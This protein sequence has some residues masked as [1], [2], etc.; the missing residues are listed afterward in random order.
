MI[1]DYIA[2]PQRS[3]FRRIIMHQCINNELTNNGESIKSQF[4]NTEISLIFWTWVLIIFF[5]I[6]HLWYWPGQE[7]SLWIIYKCRRQ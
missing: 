1:V 6:A 5:I 7:N 4:P 2:L 3:I